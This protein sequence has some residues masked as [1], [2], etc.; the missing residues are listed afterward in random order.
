MQS[1]R[2]LIS[3]QID[4]IYYHGEK[5]SDRQKASAA[6]LFSSCL[7]RRSTSELLLPAA[8]KANEPNR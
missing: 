2:K 4:C 5:K 3:F 6:S 8:H 1:I 7:S